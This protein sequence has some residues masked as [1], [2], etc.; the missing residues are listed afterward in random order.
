MV[1]SEIFQINSKVSIIIPMYNAVAKLSDTIESLFAQSYKNW[2]AI[3]V[4]DCSTDH[5]YEYAKKYEIDSRI[6]V[7]KMKKNSGPG[8]ATKYGFSK[9]SGGIVAFIDSDDVWM[10][11]KLEVQIDFMIKNNYEFT[12]TDYMQIDESGNDLNRIIKCKKIAQYKDVLKTCPVGS[13]T[14]MITADLLHKVNIPEIRKDNDYALW[15]Q[16]LRR[17]PY[18]YGMG[19]VLMQY[20]VWPQSISYNKIKKVKYHWKVYREYENFSVLKSVYLIVRYAIIK[21]LGIK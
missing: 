17:Y 8:A 12:C 16:L 10:P 19:K 4:D 14:V 15:L 5:S 20:R 21:L 7:Y 6:K 13:S 3:I 18:V 2:E 11:D 9:A 1:V